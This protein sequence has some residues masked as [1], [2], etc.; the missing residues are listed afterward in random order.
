MVVS[1]RNE[2]AAARIREAETLE[3]MY[4]T[5]AAARLQYL[6]DAPV[7]AFSDSPGARDKVLIQAWEAAAQLSRCKTLGQAL[8]SEAFEERLVSLLGFDRGGE[9][10]GL[11]RDWLAEVAKRGRLDEGVDEGPTPTRS[12]PELSAWAK[13]EGL[14]DALQASVYTVVERHSPDARWAAKRRLSTVAAL[15]TQSRLPTH[16]LG[17]AQAYLEAEHRRR[18]ELLDRE[19]AWLEG[20]TP[21]ASPRVREAF[22]RLLVLRRQ[23]R[24]RTV[25]R[26]QG[27]A[28]ALQVALDRDGPSVV[29]SEGAYYWE[30]HR[31]TL[32]VSAERVHIGCSCPGDLPSRCSKAVTALD[33]VIALLSQPPSGSEAL[34][35]QLAAE[36]ERPAWS[37]LLAELEGALTGAEDP[38]GAQA[39]EAF[40]VGWRVRS[41]GGGYT[42]NP[43]EC[44]SKA[45]GAGW[46]V[47]AARFAALWANSDGGLHGADHAVLSMLMPGPDSTPPEDRRCFVDRATAHLVLARLV[48]HPRVFG[49]R[50]TPVAV[51]RA[52]CEIAVS[53]DEE[54]R[55]HL[56][57]QLDGR[58]LD[59]GELMRVASLPVANGWAVKEDATGDFV[60][61]PMTRALKRTLDVLSRR[62]LR[63][64][65]D[66]ARALIER[67][68]TM[69]DVLPMA[70]APE[71]RGVEVV[72]DPRPH[73]GLGL[74]G[75]GQLLVRAWV[76]PLPEGGVRT[77]GRGAREVY[78]V[79]DGEPVHAVRDLD[80]ER[81]RLLAL[82]LP[83][84]TSS[85]EGALVSDVAE[86]LM[87]TERLEAAQDE[88]VVTWGERR[89]RVLQASSAG[90]V[91]FAVR[92]MKHWFGV[93]G[94]IEVDGGEV[95]LDEVLKALGSGQRHVRVKGDLWVRLE[96]Q[97]VD[98]LAPTL[99]GLHSGRHGL[100]VS[101][102]LAPV[103]E[104]LAEA[105]AVVEAPPSWVGR[106]GRMREAQGWE[107]PLPEGL[108]AELRDYQLAGYRW[109][110]RLARWADGACLADDMGLGKTLQALTLL[111]HRQAQGPALVVAP[112]SV[113]F[114]WLREAERFAPSLRVN[115]YR[116]AG[117]ER[118]LE[119]LAAGDVLVTSYDLL[120]RDAEVLAGVAWA[121]VVFDEAQAIKNADTRRA[122]AAFRL[123]AS[124]RLAL[125]GT[126]VENRT[127]ELWSLFRVIAPGLLGSLEAFTKRWVAPID[128]DQDV[129]ARARLGRLV[130]PFIL[131]RLKGEVAREL[132]ERTEVVVEVELS[133]A[134]RRLYE[135]VRKAALQVLTDE[136]LGLA[137]NERR[138]K[139]LA[140]ITRLRQLA[141][142]PKLVDEGASVGS[143][144]LKRVVELLGE[145]RD[146]GHR[147]LV[148]S[149][150]T[151]HLALVR[152]ALEAEGFAIRYL[153]G[154]TPEAKRREEVDAFQAG[155]GDVFLISLKAGGTGL[156]LTAAT[157]VLHL[158]PWWNPAVE[159]QATDRAH[160]IGQT[161][162]V[163][164][165]RLVATGTIEESILAL[166]E[167]KRAL[168][169]ALMDGTG[170]SAA[171]SA[172]ELVAL[173][174]SE[175][176]ATFGSEGDAEEEPTE[177]QAAAA[178]PGGEGH[179]RVSTRSEPA[180]AERKRADQAAAPAKGGRP[181]GSEPVAA[182]AV[183]EGALS[184]QALEE[185]FVLALADSSLGA[186]SRRNY[187]RNGRRFLEV[188]RE[189]GYE[190][191]TAAQL[192]EATWQVVELLAEGAIEAPASAV[193]LY[194]MLARKMLDL[195]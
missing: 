29:V 2:T 88:A 68:P 51:S 28:G 22:E 131:R 149:Q 122:K 154:S 72:A 179:D 9:L 171:L 173:I 182:A 163:T 89:L 123:E 186:A 49:A 70:L 141:C 78:A 38:R 144:K 126:P 191:L 181:V 148:F 152:Q 130:R 178:G 174:A 93:A 64:D 85:Q 58:P 97:L 40:E 60:L 74:V 176:S 170:S 1:Q 109:L 135:D 158:D 7:T 103:V 52:Q 150:F 175:G 128:R 59:P 194:P 32:G 102:G 65:G 27:E 39:A 36:L 138:F 73:V 160:R 114:N 86:A 42:I 25:A 79:R 46:R 6:A 30:Q 62:G 99:D 54:G 157:Y 118:L 192:S 44:R 188:L 105:G 13:D 156:N 162:A 34:A 187:E 195:L 185:A 147:A 21:P 37:R 120:A 50:S 91:R 116:G 115:A 82:A 11:L 177:Q 81:R 168:M 139:A 33:H 151:G 47:T 117:R 84:G 17:A 95:S 19:A 143:S 136:T 5:I 69:G 57:P 119:G 142:H 125:T 18:R 140:A 14:G 133:S 80:E 155:G 66:G 3:G 165:Y 111:L 172:D 31:T 166:H 180:A 183:P 87:L 107:A 53:R 94:A 15:L 41:N 67:L 16:L 137:P 190:H 96:Q 146:E 24:Q 20:L 124:F 56:Q 98:A 127:G 75:D 45:K 113:G 23:L 8:A 76:H 12:A 83:E 61:I 71:L 121:T 55:M 161:E 43:L 134:E 26:H 90:Q 4:R 92:D 184:L 159:D 101:A 132:P 189:Q 153:D 164:V 10:L 63:V 112:T 77:P 193:K 104:A 129:D 35:G 100:E 48:G 169:A 110:A 167:S 145:L 106:V 108:R